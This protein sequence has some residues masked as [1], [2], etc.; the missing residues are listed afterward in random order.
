MKNFIISSVLIAL[1][2]LMS[3]CGSSSIEGSWKI[4]PSS[5]DLVV[6]DGFPSEYKSYIEEAKNNS[7]NPE[8]IEEADKVTLQLLANGVAKINDLSHP[9]DSVS[10]NWKQTGD[11]LNL[12]GEIE[13][14]KFNVNLN[15][16][17]TSADEL[18]IGLTGESMLEQV[19]T[20][21]PELLEFPMVQMLDLDKIVK[22]SKFSIK[23]KKA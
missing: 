2:M 10:F 18:T 15:L 6:G 7:S 11:I 3:S 17:S 1:V 21:R 13:G 4:D 12:N 8:V 14:E 9:E 5:L 22:G 19:K 20:E 16:F 23:M